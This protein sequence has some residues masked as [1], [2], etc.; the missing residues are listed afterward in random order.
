MYPYVVRR[1]VDDEE[2]INDQ[3]T[4]SRILD[5]NLYPHRR[6]HV[7]DDRVR[8]AVHPD[9]MRWTA[10]Q[11]LQQPDDRAR[12]AS[13]DWIAPRHRKEDHHHHRQIDDREPPY[14]RWQKRLDEDRNQR[15]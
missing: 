9:R 3:E 1:L 8:D 14:L 12:H 11:V 13:A 5:V 4:R 10:Q 6:G 2:P 15:N 7:S